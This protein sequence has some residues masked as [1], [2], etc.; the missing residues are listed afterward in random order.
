[1]KSWVVLGMASIDAVALS[2]FGWPRVKLVQALQQ[3][4]V[5]AACKTQ[6]ATAISHKRAGD[7]V[8]R[9]AKKWDARPTAESQLTIPRKSDKTFILELPRQGAAIRS[10][11]R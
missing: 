6:T 9:G 5:S 4:E 2:R 10:C 8:M 3:D 1:M 11:F 7:R